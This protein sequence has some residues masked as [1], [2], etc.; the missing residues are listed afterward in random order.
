MVVIA[1][2]GMMQRRLGLVVVQEAVR[3]LLRKQGKV[4]RALGLVELEYGVLWRNRFRRVWLRLHSSEGLC[5][6][7]SLNLF[8]HVLGRVK[9]P[10]VVALSGCER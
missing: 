5:V 2:H 9:A 7:F 10:E 6:F 8:P 4:R 1:A 3:V